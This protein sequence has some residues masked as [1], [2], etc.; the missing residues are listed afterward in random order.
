MALRLWFPFTGDTRNN[1]LHSSTV[2]SSNL[3]YS[4]NGKIGKCCNF[5]TGS[6]ILG[7]QSFLTNSTEDWSYCCW[8]NLT[9][10][11]AGQCLFSCRNSIN[12]TGITIFYYSTQ[13]YIDDGARWQF[14][15]TN[16]IAVNTWYHICV[17]RKKGVGVYL[18]V[19]GE[20]DSSTSVT[21]TPT[22]VCTT[23][24]SVGSS[25]GTATTI[26][27]NSVKG[28]LN[29]VRVYD[30]ALSVK[31]I[32]EISKGLVCHYTMTNTESTLTNNI[33]YDSSGL[34][35]HMNIVGTPTISVDTARNIKCMYF[36]KNQYA[37]S[38]Y[39]SNS[40]YLP[41]SSITVSL[42][43]NYMT[44]SMNPISCTQSGGWNF[45]QPTNG[46]LDFG[47]YITGSGYA[48]VYSVTPVSSLKGQWHMITGT[49]DGNCSKVYIDGVCESTNYIGTGL[50]MMYGS[51]ARLCIAAEANSTSPEATTY[52]G[53]ISDVRIYG[54]AL[55]ADDIMDLYNRPISISKTGET[56]IQGELLESNIDHV[57]FQKTGVIESDGETDKIS[58]GEHGFLEYNDITRIYKAGYMQSVDFNEY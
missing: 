46:L 23:N 39:L 54:T 13:W 20:L 26:N 9:E 8:M 19:N 36:I 18:Y 6:Y 38:P 33:L 53:S 32:K 50:T 11:T 27:G 14:T 52:V 22:D 55:S 7:T 44:F 12:S 40:G 15:P 34:N 28:A 35:N 25:Q 37:M 42:W 31:E 45:N 49:F 29:D 58:V 24:F 1:G 48:H 57:R 3:T 4:N 17:V 56:Y 30:H 47:I 21:H 16:T 51:T 2:T 10:G 41:R 5:T 43:M